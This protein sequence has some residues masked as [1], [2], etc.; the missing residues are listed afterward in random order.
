MHRE[1][2]MLHLKLFTFLE[3]LYT[4]LAIIPIAVIMHTNQH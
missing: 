3:S 4:S 1:T 2:A